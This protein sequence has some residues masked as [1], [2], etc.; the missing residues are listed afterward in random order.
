M[1]FES[2]K[3]AANVSDA[4][5]YSR[6]I[7]CYANKKVILQGR[8]GEITG[9]Y[10][11]RIEVPAGAVKNHVRNVTLKHWDASFPGTGGYVDA[12]SAT[13]WENLYDD[14]AGAYMYPLAP[15]T[16]ITVT[17]S[18]FTYTN[19]SGQRIEVILQTGVV[20]QLRTLHGADSWLS[21]TGIPGAHIL[22]PSESIEVSYSSAP[23]M[24]YLPLN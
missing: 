8:G 19:N 12:G 11:Q 1:G 9:G 20:T 14:K 4:G 2:P 22:A 23:Q 24:S 13:E 21:P 16:K 3:A 15:R 6:F 17:G 18:P 5:I 7:N 10:Y